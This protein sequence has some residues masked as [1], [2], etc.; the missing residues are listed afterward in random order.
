MCAGVPSDALRCLASHR[1][2]I[3]YSFDE[4]ALMGSGEH[5][6]EVRDPHDFQDTGP[7][8]V[9][10]SRW[11]AEVAL[12]EYVYL[13]TRLPHTHRL[14]CS[15]LPG[16]SM[17]RPTYT[18]PWSCRFKLPNWRAPQALHLDHAHHAAWAG[19]AFSIATAPGVR[20]GNSPAWDLMSLTSTRVRAHCVPACCLR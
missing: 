2:F 5:D 16:R 18:T 7:E 19:R 12:F 1:S 4:L 14:K 13:S 3:R 20:N 15:Q 6:V 9:Y 8:S 10:P 11:R 17:R